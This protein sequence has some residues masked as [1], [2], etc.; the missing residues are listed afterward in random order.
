MGKILLL[1]DFLYILDHE[2]LKL[3]ILKGISLIIGKITIEVDIE[4]I[5]QVA[6]IDFFIDDD[7]KF[8]TDAANLSWCFNE[9]TS[10]PCNI[11][12]VA[13]DS[14]DSI[15]AEDDLDALIYNFGSKIFKES[16][17]NDNIIN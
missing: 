5:E 6:R 15:V 1:L 10:G 8:S 16:I 7:L 12:V 17:Y 2:L 13:Y 3:R 4:N 14:H 9:V 11:R